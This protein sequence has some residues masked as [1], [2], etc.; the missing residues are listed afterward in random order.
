MVFFS[1]PSQ[2]IRSELKL[3]FVSFTNITLTHPSQ[4][5]LVSSLLFLNLQETEEIK[6]SQC[7][8]NFCRM[9]TRPNSVDGFLGQS[10]V[11]RLL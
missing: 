2:I 6:M 8:V 3:A 10:T 4:A 5:R 11:K 7:S 9:L 1:F